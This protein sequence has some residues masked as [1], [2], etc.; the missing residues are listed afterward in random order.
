M[1]Y[2]ERYQINRTVCGGGYI[3]LLGVGKRI[4]VASFQRIGKYE[5]QSI[6]LKI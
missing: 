3:G 2:E 6:V 5:I 1:F 4:I